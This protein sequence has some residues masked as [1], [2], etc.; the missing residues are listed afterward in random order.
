MTLRLWATLLTITLLLS[1]IN[2]SAGKLVVYSG[3]PLIVKTAKDNPTEVQFRDDE[4]ASIVLG[5]PAQA[6]SLQNTPNSLFIQPLE[7]GVSGDIFIVLKDGRTRILSL[8]PTSPEER[9][10]LLEVVDSDEQ[11]ASRMKQVNE[12]GLTPAGLIRVMVLGTDMGGVTI[13]KSNQVILEGPVKIVAHT[14]YDAVS[15]KGYIA[16]L[17]NPDALDLK[18]ISSENL[19][20]SAVYKGKAY[21]VFMQ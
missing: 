3:S 20:A 16:D 18:S 10:R 19:L 6:I 15:M 11:A 8:I 17:R 4:I 2:A 1:A 9:D 21:F 13:N 7:M 12:S 14:L 5:I